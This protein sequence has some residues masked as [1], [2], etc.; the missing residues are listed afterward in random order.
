MAKIRLRKGE[1]VGRE[2]KFYAPSDDV[3][4][5]A[6]GIIRG[7]LD[8]EGVKERRQ[9]RSKYGVRRNA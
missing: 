6:P 1:F 4:N 8:C 2:D 7:A 3:R 9:S 5:C